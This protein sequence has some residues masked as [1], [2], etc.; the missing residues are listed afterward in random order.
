MDLISKKDL[1]VQ[2]G[3]SYGQ[4]YR[5]KREGL[6]PEDWFIKQSSYTGQETYFP[7]EQML[8]RV[9]AILTSK[10]SYSL[11]QL[12]AMFSPESATDSNIPAS[13]LSKLRELH[14]ALL[15]LLPQAQEKNTYTFWD[16]VL[17]AMLSKVYAA[18]S[19]S[20]TQAV[21]LLKKAAS[22]ADMLTTTDTNCTVFLSGESYHLAF[23]RD[24]R[25]ILFDGSIQAKAIYPLSEIA[26]DLK[27]K[28]GTNFVKL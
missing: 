20:E 15:A 12:A 19:L 17:L 22:V 24:V 7:Q 14:P 10:D 6:I 25:P 13:S 28:Y 4:L 23:A 21:D 11:E 18:F 2:T 9:Q 5:W 26:N 8:E 27:L 3:I 1:L 16:V